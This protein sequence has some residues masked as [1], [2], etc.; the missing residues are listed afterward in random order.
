[1]KISKIASLCLVGSAAFIIGCGTNNNNSG[2]SDKKNKVLMGTVV[3][4]IVVNGVVKVYAGSLNSN[5]L[6]TTRTDS[7]GNYSLNID[8]YS[9]PLLISVSCDNNSSFITNNGY[10][11]QCDLQKP[12]LSV[13]MA[14]GQVLK[15]NVSPISTQLV[16]LATNGNLNTTITSENL[17]KAKK[18]I[19]YI[20]GIDPVIVNPLTDSN[21][22]NLI[23]VF[24]KVADENGVSVMDLV[25]DFENDMKDGVIGNNEIMKQIFNSLKG[26]IKTPMLNNNNL[27]INIS[28]IENTS[29]PY[30]GIIATKNVVQSLRNNLYSISNNKDQNGTLDKEIKDFNSAI[31]RDVIKNTEIQ[32]D[33][34]GYILNAVFDPDASMSG[35]VNK[36]GNTY[37]YNV[38]SNSNNTQFDYTITWNGKDYKGVIKTSQD[39]KNIN[40]P[41]DLNTNMFVDINGSLPSTDNKTIYAKATAHK[42]N[43][44]TFN[45]DLSDVKIKGDKDSLQI[46]NVNIDGKYFTYTDSDGDKDGDLNYI[47]LNNI[48]LNSK[49][50]N[51]FE[52]NGVLSLN[53]IQNKYINNKYPQGHYSEVYWLQTNVTCE[54]TNGDQKAPTGGYVILKFNGKNY[55]LKQSWNDEIQMAFEINDPDQDG[56]MMSDKDGDLEEYV[57]NKDNYNLSNVQC[58]SGYFPKIEEINEDMG[59]DFANEGYIPNKITFNGIVKDVT[60]NVEL[61]GKIVSTSN[62][63]QNIDLTK[64]HINPTISTSLNI[65]L[66]RPYYP[67]TMLNANYIYNKNKTSKLDLS[68]FYKNNM[69]TVLGNWKA[70]QSGDVT[71]TDENGVKINI[72]VNTKGDIIFDETSVTFNG[73]KVGNLENRGGDLPV[74]HFN[75]GSVESIY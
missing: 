47:K 7:Y 49:I 5:L 9:G 34:F 51:Q 36:N 54:N 10:R 6:A 50:N 31:S 2:D 38:V 48:E 21:Y 44:K 42:N 43:D 14:D 20:Y 66:K 30:S 17:Q 22:K 39:Y 12:L 33:V 64:D 55:T 27:E 40:S 15:G 75:D 4:E 29:I 28:K 13:N 71:I 70:D 67:D 73:E 52:I 65:I 59:S 24:H 63:I 45:F 35:T 8:N 26:V 53:W 1:M 61:N 56:L 18:V 3:D 37:Y 72:P 58:P 25:E 62:D 68:Y 46:Q 60:T 41:D 69:I 23:D 11:I 74:I 16:Y 57:E 19:S 32:L